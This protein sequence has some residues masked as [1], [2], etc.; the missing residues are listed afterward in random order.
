MIFIYLQIDS[1]TL[2]YTRFDVMTSNIH[3]INFIYKNICISNRYRSIISIK[4]YD[5]LI[6]RISTYNYLNRKPFKII[7]TY[8]LIERALYILL[9]SI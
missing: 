9:K 7:D 5:C 1:N 6:F 4:A 8:E 2:T 3:K